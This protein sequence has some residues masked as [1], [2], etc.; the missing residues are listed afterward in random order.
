MP[1]PE[2]IPAVEPGETAAV[3]DGRVLPVTTERRDNEIRLT[4]GPVRA[5]VGSYGAN[6]QITALSGDGAVVIEPGGKILVSMEGLAPTSEFTG[7]LYSDPVLLGRGTADANGRIAREFFVP[8]VEAG[9]HRFVVS[10]VDDT[11]REM[12]LTYGVVLLGEGEGVG[13]TTV[14]LIVLGL[15]TGVALF[16]PAALKRRRRSPV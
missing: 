1:G 11:N 14:V 13:I 5:V 3:I 12:T 8:E 10:L 6:G 4:V 16:L 2:D 9:G 7:V 15:G